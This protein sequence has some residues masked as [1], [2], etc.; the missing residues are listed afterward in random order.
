MIEFV[1]LE[2]QDLP[3]IDNNI[4]ES[5]NLESQDLPTVDYKP[6]E[7]ETTED[8]D[9]ICVSSQCS[10]PFK[11]NEEYFKVENLFGE[12]TSDYQRNIAKNNLGIGSA[13]DLIWEN[14]KGN[15]KNSTLYNIVINGINEQNINLTAEL[16]KTIKELINYVQN[17]TSKENSNGLAYFNITPIEVDYSGNP[18]SVTINWEYTTNITEQTINGIS[19][20]PSIRTYTFYNIISSFQIALNYKGTNI[21][22]TYT[23]TFNV[24]YPVFYG[25]SYDISKAYSKRTFPITTT[26]N[27]NE[28][29]FIFTLNQTDLY[30][31]GFMGG[32]ILYGTTTKYNKT[33]YVYKSAEQNLG[34]ITINDK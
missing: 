17:Y 22:N 23:T 19:L 8:T 1:N 3:L 12:L 26:A 31:N 18:V 11:C 24:Y 25:T 7:V 10:S 20:D 33:Y 34:T 6:I 14:I 21:N 30:V 29:I 32:F 13:Y 4:P 16:N 9:S 28:N 15:P 2:S 5:V 27:E